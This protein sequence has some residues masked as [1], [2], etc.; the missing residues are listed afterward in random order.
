MQSSSEFLPHRAQQ[1][2][3]DAMQEFT[4]TAILAY[5]CGYSEPLVRDEVGALGTVTIGKDFQEVLFP[6]SELGCISNFDGELDWQE[7][8]HPASL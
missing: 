1:S 2:K 3:Q 5:E 6:T 8:D 4:A 7:H